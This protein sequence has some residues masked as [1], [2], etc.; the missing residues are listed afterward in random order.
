[1]I[2]NSRQ[3]H[4]LHRRCWCANVDSLGLDVTPELRNGQGCK[5]RKFANCGAGQDDGPGSHSAK[6]VD[7]HWSCEHLV[8]VQGDAGHKLG[9]VATDNAANRTHM[10]P[11][12]HGENLLPKLDLQ[13]YFAAVSEQ[14]GLAF[15]CCNCQ[16]FRK[17]EACY[18]LL[19]YAAIA[20][21]LRQPGLL[22]TE[23][24]HVR[25]GDS[26]GLVADDAVA[27][28]LGAEEAIDDIQCPCAS[29]DVAIEDD[30]GLH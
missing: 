18:M 23:S 24:E 5:S 13:N 29:D 30:C 2:L 4:Y 7:N 10:E 3:R 6:V 1:M 26:W 19:E 21:Q 27:A 8:D 28:D 15:A 20:K 11:V 25:D 16:L 14:L 22:V 9:G 12:R 17:G